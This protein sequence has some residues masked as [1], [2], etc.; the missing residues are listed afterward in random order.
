MIM[1]HVCMRACRVRLEMLPAGL[2]ASAPPAFCTQTRLPADSMI[3]A[4]CPM[5]ATD[6]Y[7]VASRGVRFSHSALRSCRTKEHRSCCTAVGVHMGLEQ[8]D[9]QTLPRVTIQCSASKLLIGRT[10]LA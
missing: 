7:P 6:L 5:H 9:S 2:R 8:S 10:C 4:L 1:D 3:P